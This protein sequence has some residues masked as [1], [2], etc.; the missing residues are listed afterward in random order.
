MKS[1]R[2]SFILATVSLLLLLITL[3]VIGRMALYFVMKYP[4]GQPSKKFYPEL[5][6]IQQAS[7]SQTNDKFDILILGGSAISREFGL[8]INKTLDSL[9]N[10]S[11]NNRKVQI[12]NAAT[13]SHTSLDNLNKYNLLAQK[14]FDLVIYYEAI[15][16]TRANNIPPQDF[17]D[18]YQ[19]IMWYYDMAL[20]KHHPEINWTV[21]PFIIHKSFNLSI[22]KLKGKHFLDL[23]RVN[24]DFV[25]YGEDIKTTNPYHHNV[26]QIV[27]EA[28]KRREKV[29]LMTYALYVPPSVT[30][31]GGYTDYRDFAGCQYPSPLWLWG[32][33][34][35][36]Q[37]GVNQHNLAIRQ[38]AAQYKTY[39][40]DMDKELPRTKD[41]YCDL[42]HLTESGGEEFASKLYQYMIENNLL[43]P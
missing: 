23:Q 32:D 25:K 18:N 16:D 37:S 15:N 40:F 30:G 8:P 34:V 35:N 43:T 38:I 22:D 3:E 13:P 36:V 21:L 10:Q 27:V 19:H 39:L 26:A 9:L 33:P 29:L 5:E 17:S 1:K 42:C 12:F 7:I 2:S 31:N 11:A 20:M 24:P 4:F 6:K 14:H 28:Q 41:F